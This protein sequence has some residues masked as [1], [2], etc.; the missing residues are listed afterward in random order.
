[1]KKEP[2]QKEPVNPRWLTWAQKIQSI[3]QSGLLYTGNPFDVER[4]HELSMIAQEMMVEGTKA[5]PGVVQVVFD[6]QC[7]YA[8]P[9]LDIRGVIFNDEKVLLVRELADGGRWTLPGGWVDINESPSHAVEREV[10]E[11]AGKLV[12]ARKLLAVYD[13]N[14]HGHP[15]TVFHSYKIFVLC[16]LLGEATASVLETSDPTFF[17]LSEMPE[18]SPSR[19]TPEEI[20]RMFEHLHDPSLP[21][22]F[23]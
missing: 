20:S 18:L 16:D 6:A 8:T 2:G 21:T 12:K 14:Q 4:Y 9:K 10:L 7:G 23:D 13:R 5:D 11:E 22:F 15:P 17:L 19:V 3:A 1:M